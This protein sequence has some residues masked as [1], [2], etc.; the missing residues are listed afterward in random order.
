MIYFKTFDK[1]VVQNR[2]L[3]RRKGVSVF[4]PMITGIIKTAPRL[5]VNNRVWKKYSEETKNQREYDKNRSRQ[6]DG[7]YHKV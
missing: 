2:Q 6:R 3:R 7:R 4:S 1:V 5:S